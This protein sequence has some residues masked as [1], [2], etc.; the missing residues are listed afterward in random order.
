MRE[1]TGEKEE[2]GEGV[3]RGLK[4]ISDEYVTVCDFYP[5]VSCNRLFHRSEP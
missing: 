3:R 2:A 5:A 1:A 4:R